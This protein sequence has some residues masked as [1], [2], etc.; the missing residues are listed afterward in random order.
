MLPPAPYLI[1]GF[2]VAPG[3]P[4]AEAIIA[5]IERD[6]PLPAGKFPVALPIPDTYLIQCPKNDPDTPF[7][8]IASFLQLQDQNL[9]GG[10]LWLVQCC[11][12]N[13]IA[14]L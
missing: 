9:G 4:G 11:R 8:D 13:E 14:G 2:T 7:Q 12:S 6:L 10:L 3:T 1:V 5:Q